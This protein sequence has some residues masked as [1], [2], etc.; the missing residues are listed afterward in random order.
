MGSGA[1]ASLLTGHIVIVADLSGVIHHEKVVILGIE[2]C[3]FFGI[4][5]EI[6]GEFMDGAVL[7]V[8]L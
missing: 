3:M 8:H 1:V 6:M 7:F 5:T 2:R 4:S